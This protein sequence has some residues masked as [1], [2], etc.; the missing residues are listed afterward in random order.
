MERLFGLRYV[1]P[2]DSLEW[3]ALIN[4]LEHAKAVLLQPCISSAVTLIRRNAE[5]VGIR[6]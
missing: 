1:L 2:R 3:K 5:P 6:S 4:G